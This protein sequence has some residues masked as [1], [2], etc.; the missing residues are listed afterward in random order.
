MREEKLKIKTVELYIKDINAR[1]LSFFSLRFIN[2]CIG[3]VL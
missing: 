2:I 1:K 3:Y